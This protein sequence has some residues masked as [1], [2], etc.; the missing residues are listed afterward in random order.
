MTETFLKVS[1]AAAGN[2]SIA[3]AAAGTTATDLTPRS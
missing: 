3:T 2:V 1:L